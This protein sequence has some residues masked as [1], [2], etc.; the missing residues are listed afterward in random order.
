MF[1]S[2]LYVLFSWMPT[3]VSVIF[4][5]IIAICLII[6][7]LKLIGFLLDVIPFL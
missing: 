3:W 1:L 5:I 6:L 7:I 4:G 2:M